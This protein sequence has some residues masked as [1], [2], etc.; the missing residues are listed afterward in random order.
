MDA[1]RPSTSDLVGLFRQRL[2]GRLLDCNDSC[3]QM[4]GYD[5]REELLAAGFEYVNASDFAAITAALPDVPL[6]SNVEV[7]LR[8]RGGGVAWVLQ[9]LKVT[10]DAIEG[11]MFDVTE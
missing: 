10:G 2:G 9:N 7:A 8:K 1:S 6:L 11:A 3:A 4:L 5:S